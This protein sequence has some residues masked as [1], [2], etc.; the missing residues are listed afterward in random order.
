MTVGRQH[1]VLA[2]EIAAPLRQ[3]DGDAAGERHV[4]FAPAQGLHRVMGGHQRRRTG[5]LEVHARPLEV[6]DVADAGGHEILVV[7]GVTQKEH[8][9]VIHQPAVRA[10]VEIEIA[11][12]AAAAVHADMSVQ[13]FRRVA[14]VLHGLP[15][16]FKKLSVLGIEDRRLFRAEAEEF[17]IETVE[18]LEPGRGGDVVLAADQV[19]A[20]AGFEQRRLVQ[21]LDRFDTVTQVGPERLGRTGPGDAKRQADDGNVF[22][23]K[24]VSGLL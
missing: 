11:A 16:R 14:G 6:K 7:P 24:A 13:A 3:F 15:G 22:V 12:H 18:T 8:A 17:G 23:C 5:G 9:H 21:E 20:L 1:L 4:A 19:G 10:D 2:V